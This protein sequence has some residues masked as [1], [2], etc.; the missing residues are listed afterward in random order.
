VDADLIIVET[1]PPTTLPDMQHSG[2]W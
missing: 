1:E 2:R